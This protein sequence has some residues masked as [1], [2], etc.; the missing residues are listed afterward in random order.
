PRRR[1]LRQGHSAAG[2]RPG[3]RAG[4]DRR[5]LAGGDV[6]APPPARDAG[7][8]RVGAGPDGVAAPQA[9]PRPGAGHQRGGCEVQPA[10]PARVHRQRRRGPQERPAPGRGEAVM[11]RRQTLQVGGDA[12]AERLAVAAAS[13]VGVLVPPWAV[14]IVVWIA[15]AISHARW[16]Q[17][18]A[19]AWVAMA[20]TLVSVAL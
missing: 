19:V 17:P 1:R 8:G 9:R 7:R 2:A 20:G 14:L 11:A 15:A 6:E 12:A 16:G 5:D 10:V 18:P 3:G 13:R 4:R